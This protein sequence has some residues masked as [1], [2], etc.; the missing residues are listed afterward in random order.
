MKRKTSTRVT[1]SNSA[2]M[3]SVLIILSSQSNI[4]IAFLIFYGPVRAWG[5]VE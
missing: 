2:S 3:K 5:V 1:V 4:A